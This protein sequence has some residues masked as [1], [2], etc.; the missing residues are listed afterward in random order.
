MSNPSLFVKDKE[1]DA[2]PARQAFEKK[3]SLSTR[4]ATAIALSAW[5]RNDIPFFLKAAQSGFDVQA[6]FIDSNT[7]P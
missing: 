1:Q 4:Y 6:P 5:I 7:N 3:W 2:I